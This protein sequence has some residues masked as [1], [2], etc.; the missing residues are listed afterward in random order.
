V[1]GGGPK[2]NVGSTMEEVV[3]PDTISGIMRLTK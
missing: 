2:G 1:H 3:R